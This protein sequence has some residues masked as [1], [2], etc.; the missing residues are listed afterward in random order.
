MT[1]KEE[2]NTDV[3]IL[4]GFNTGMNFGR[5]LQGSPSVPGQSLTAAFVRIWVKQL[6]GLS[7]RVCQV[8]ELIGSDWGGQ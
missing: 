5:P 6:K 8:L 1:A 4:W 3:I 7:G 2:T